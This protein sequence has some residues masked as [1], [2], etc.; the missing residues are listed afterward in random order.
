MTPKE[1]RDWKPENDL[2]SLHVWARAENAEAHQLAA[3]Q[4]H[5]LARLRDRLVAELAPEVRAKVA[6]RMSRQVEDA[7]RMQAGAGSPA[8]VAGDARKAA[9]IPDW[10]LQ[11]RGG[12]PMPW[13]RRSRRGLIRPG[14]FLPAQLLAALRPS[15][16]R[17]LAAL[18]A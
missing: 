11:G 18:R 3:W 7:R 10:I 16:A 1:A 6:A 14:A 9:V 13:P 5:A 12:A 4:P 2:R 17:A 15:A 8:D